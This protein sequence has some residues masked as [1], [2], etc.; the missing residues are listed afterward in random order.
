[1]T[2]KNSSSASQYHKNK[3]HHNWL[4]YKL[5]DQFFEMNKDAFKGDLYDLGCGQAPYKD[6]LSPMIDTYTGVDWEGSPHDI[7]ADIKASLSDTLPIKENVADCVLAVSVLEHIDEPQI[8]INETFR[9]LKPG[10]SL[11]YQ[12]PWQWW[13]HEAPYD[14][15]R[16]SPYALEKMLTKAGFKNI[17]IKPMGGF[18]T[19]LYLKKNYFLKRSIRG[20]KFLRYILKAAFIPLYYVFQWVAPIMDK[21]DKDWML[22]TCAYSV[23]ATKP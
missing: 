16:Y 2:D 10:G 11:V 15:F 9:I 21:L 1:M 6:Y 17:E 14:F 18:F 20:P 5:L 7:H 23:R 22:E 13:I 4:A 19:M 12:V 8:M 3:G